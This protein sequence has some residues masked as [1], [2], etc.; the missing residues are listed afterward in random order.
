MQDA[1]A[2]LH[3]MAGERPIEIAAFLLGLGFPEAFLRRW[4]CYGYRFE[5][6]SKVVAISGDTV[7]IATA[8]GL[9][10]TSDG[11][12]TWRCVQ[13]VDAIRGGAAPRRRLGNSRG[14]DRSSREA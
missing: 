10:I 9:R 4:T 2:F 5:A 13:A 8:D 6:E 11:G 1:F 7:Y 3:A 12:A 14:G